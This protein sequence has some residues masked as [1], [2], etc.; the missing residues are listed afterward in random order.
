MPKQYDFT[1]DYNACYFH[2]LYKPDDQLRRDIEYHRNNILRP[3]SRSPTLVANEERKKLYTTIGIHYHTGDTL[4]LGKYNDDSTANQLI[5]GW[6]QMYDCSIALMKQLVLNQL[7]DYD[8]GRFYLVTDSPTVREHVRQLF[9]F[10]NSNSSKS[11]F[12]TILPFVTVHVVTEDLESN[13]SFLRGGKSGDERSAL[14][15]LYLLSEC[16]GIVVNTLPYSGSNGTVVALTSPFAALAKKI[17][18]VPNSNF[19]RCAVE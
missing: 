13:D 19:Y 6:N 7:D 3:T 8:I 2:I 1:N 16:D 4:A 12:S 14:L 17:G 11:A 9:A 10:E 15:E 18:F 5:S